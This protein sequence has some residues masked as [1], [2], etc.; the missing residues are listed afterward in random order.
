MSKQQPIV[1]L[2]NVNRFPET[3]NQSHNTCLHTGPYEITTRWTMVMK[4]MLLSRKPELVFTGTS[5]MGINP[6]NGKFSSH[7]DFWDSI[8]N[9]EY[10]SLEGLWDVFR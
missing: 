9:N 6:K 3:M 5:V 8:A 1:Y 7:V 2:A 10:F 4:F